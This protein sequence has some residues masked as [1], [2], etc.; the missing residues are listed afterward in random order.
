MDVKRRDFLKIAGLSAIAGVGAPSALN[1]LLKGEAHASG[2]AQGHGSADAHGAAVKSG[3]R[4]GLVIDV[5]KFAE[6]HG[7]AEKCIAACNLKY[8]G[9]QK[10]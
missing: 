5:N 7:L 4:Y 6:N 3:K 1:M 10:P 2:A 8:C 9:S